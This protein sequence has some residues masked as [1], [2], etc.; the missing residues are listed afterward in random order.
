MARIGIKSENLSIKLGKCVIRNISFELEGGDILGI[1]GRSGSGKS[2][3]MKAIIGKVRVAGGTLETFSD[4]KKAPLTIGYSPQENSLYPFL[5][6]QENIM[7]FGQLYGMKNSEIIKRM[8]MLLKRL[9]LADAKDKKIIHLSGGM[10]KRADLAV[11]L[12]HDPDLI[13]LDEPFNGLDISLQKFIWALLRE[14]G[15]SGKIIIIS[16]HMLN[17][18]QNNCNQFGL[19]ERGVFYNTQQ[20]K[21]LLQSNKNMSFEQFLQWIFTND[22]ARRS[23]E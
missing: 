8:G 16:S 1:A 3:V 6:V 18:I 4:L 5:S 10:Q 19:V 21:R 2:T 20:L 17:D 14:L 11:T 7:T 23:D 15:A 12:I 9:D 22:Y 13:I